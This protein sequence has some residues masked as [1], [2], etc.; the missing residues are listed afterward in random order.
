[1][2]NCVGPRKLDSYVTSSKKGSHKI[3]NKNHK[4][5]S[6]YRNL[7]SRKH[8]CS[9]KIIY[10]QCVLENVNNAVFSLLPPIPNKNLFLK[11]KH[12]ILLLY[13][14][15]KKFKTLNY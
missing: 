13:S 3:V 7:F 14:V 12:I 8:S 9:H 10:L 4:N 1:M 2:E 5:N 11:L 15:L 6:T